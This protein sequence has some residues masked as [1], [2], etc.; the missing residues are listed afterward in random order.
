[1]LSELSSVQHASQGRY[2]L[3]T[4]HA[5]ALS[6]VLALVLQLYNMQ[7]TIANDGLVTIVVAYS[8]LV[9]TTTLA[10]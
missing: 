1:M 3:R 9:G 4:V 7:A 6:V 2:L 8:H 5:T 10:L